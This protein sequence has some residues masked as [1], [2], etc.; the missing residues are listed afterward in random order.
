MRKR[1]YTAAVTKAM[2]LLTLF[3][4]SLLSLDAVSKLYLA[5]TRTDTSTASNTELKTFY[6][7]LILNH[8]G[9][10][11]LVRRCNY[12]VQKCKVLLR[13]YS[14]AMSGFQQIMEQNPYSYDALVAHWDYMATQLLMQGSGG[15]E[16]SDNND[17]YD[18]DS[19]QTPGR[20]PFTKEQRRQISETITNVY[21]E[22][23]TQ[24]EKKLE[25][26][27][28]LSK[29]G[30]IKAEKELAEKNALKEAVKP[31]HP[32]NIQEH[33]NIVNGD[34]QKLFA[35]NK[36]NGSNGEHNLIPDKFSL[37]QNYPNPFN[38]VTKINYALPSDVKVVIKIYDILGREVKTLI[39]EFKKAGYY[40]I[41]FDGT[42]LATGV[43]F[44]RIEAGEFVQSKKMVLVK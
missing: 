23:N 42:N 18:S 17:D 13:Q 14:S 30:D 33:I 41:S 21:N 35:V 5:K 39:N 29:K 16:S 37:G 22:T 32:K 19:L 20:S 31:L 24:E 3:P 38:P 34:I 27:K 9:N 43:Y 6:E 10:I 4:D 2:S 7:T 36:S 28:E 15:G 25:I 26:L 12:F 1:N 44:Y 40:D 8:S 11:P